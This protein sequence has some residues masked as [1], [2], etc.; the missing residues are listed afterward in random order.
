LARGRHGRRKPDTRTDPVVEERS[1]IDTGEA[2]AWKA[3][4]DRFGTPERDRTYWLSM[5]LP[6]WT[7]ARADAVGLWLDDAF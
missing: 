1:L 5:L 7:A 4:R 6:R 3:A 2:T